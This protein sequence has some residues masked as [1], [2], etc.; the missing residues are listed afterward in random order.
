MCISQGGIVFINESLKDAFDV[1]FD[2]GAI[3]R[4]IVLCVRGNIGQEQRAKSKRKKGRYAQSHEHIL[5]E[6]FDQLH[7]TQAGN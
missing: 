7:T 4:A 6:S 5:R 1:S 2:R 3:S